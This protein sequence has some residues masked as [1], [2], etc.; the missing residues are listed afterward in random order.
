[1][2]IA[3]GLNIPL[4]KGAVVALIIIIGTAVPNAPSNV[5]SF[6]FFSVVGLTLFGVDK[7]A[8]AG[9]SLISYA[10]FT[11][12]LWVLGYIALV[13]SGINLSHIRKELIL[14]RKNNGTNTP[15]S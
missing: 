12:P 13:S 14:L 3:C 4:W 8:A 1:M 9:F 5:G 15:V 7:T 6:Q 2:M 11:I 10:F